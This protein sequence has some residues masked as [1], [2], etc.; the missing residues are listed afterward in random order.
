MPMSLLTRDNGKPRARVFHSFL[1]ECCPESTLKRAHRYPD[2]VFARMESR[3]D[4]TFVALR[5][6]FMACFPPP[7]QHTKG[8]PMTIA[9]DI[10]RLKQ[11]EDVLRFASFSEEDAWNL[12]SA[13][14]AMA[15]ARNLPLV[16]DIRIGIRPLFYAAMPRTTPENPDWVKRKINTVYRFEASSYRVALE[17]QGNGK[18]FDQS[19]GIDTMLYANAG[20]GF[21]LR[22]GGNMVGAVTVSGVPQRDDHNFVAENLAAFLKVDYATV[23]LP[24]ESA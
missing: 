1:S 5:K 10:A 13:M 12:G 4:A 7:P 19:R 15:L 2:L 22:I 16:M 14:R 3:D 18:A 11:Q 23:Q 17:Y 21:P 9:D 8:Q 6:R 20:G 24:I